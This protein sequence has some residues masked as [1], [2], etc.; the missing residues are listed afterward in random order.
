VLRGSLEK[1]RAGAYDPPMY[2]ARKLAIMAGASESGVGKALKELDAA[3]KLV[4]KLTSQ[5]RRA[6][7]VG[8]THVYVRMYRWKD[9]QDAPTTGV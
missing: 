8:K 1:A 2:Q 7:M 5:V 3:G 6:G 9:D 4:Y